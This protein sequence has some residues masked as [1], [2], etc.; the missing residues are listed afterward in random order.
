MHEAIQPSLIYPDVIIYLELSPEY[1]I[2]RIKKRSRDCEDGIPIEY[3]LSLNKAYSKVLSSLSKRCKVVNIDA[4]KSESEVL[5]DV[6][7]VL[8]TV[9]HELETS[10]H[11]CYK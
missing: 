3:L 6:E 5:T 1:T 8:D 4:R 11:P 10:E 9:K 7:K 2:E